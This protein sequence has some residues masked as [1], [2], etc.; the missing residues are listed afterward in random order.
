MDDLVVWV[1]GTFTDGTV[2]TGATDPGF[3]TGVGVFETLRTIA[4][5]PHAVDRHLAR[6]VS[7]AAI[8]GVDLPVGI[9]ELTSVVDTVAD[10]WTS[11]HPGDARLRITV[12][13]GGRT[14]VTAT[15]FVPHPPT[16]TVVTS[17]WVIN[18]HAPTTGAK[19]T[20]YADNLAA[21]ADAHQRGA[22]ETLRAN[23]T[24]DL[25]EAATANVFAVINDT[26]V[27]PPLSA[28]CLPGVTRHIV[29]TSGCG[30]TETT[31][32]MGA[33]ADITELFLTSVIR[34]V[35]PV[36]ALNGTTIGDGTPG[37]HT[38]AAVKAL[39]DFRGLPHDG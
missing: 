38:T 14:V 26:L 25:C 1:D 39:N 3:T 29:L 23:T 16:A 32:P 7:S 28:G 37:P 36:T 10:T 30:A 31:I 5:R 21:L 33:M 8:T 9:G 12:T 27:T 34:G 13:G 6:L 11:Q 4:R 20:S 24:G 17:P 35:Q 2:T 15:A 22:D 19:T 18:E